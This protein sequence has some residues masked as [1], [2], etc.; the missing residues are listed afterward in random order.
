MTHLLPQLVL[1]PVHA[2]M[3]WLY[4]LGSDKVAA[5]GWRRFDHAIVVV[6]ALAW[7]FVAEGTH[8][9]IGPGEKLWATVLATALGFVI[10]STIL[11]AGWCIRT[12][13]GDSHAA[14]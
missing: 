6:A 7:V 4:L 11:A 10:F 5:P 2:V 14:R 13:R 12:L 1:L 8:R 9:V 3:A